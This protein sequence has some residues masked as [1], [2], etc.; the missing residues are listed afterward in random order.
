M[1]ILTISVPLGYKMLSKNFSI[2][3]MTKTIISKDALSD[4]LL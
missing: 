4:E 3:F 1:K 2:N